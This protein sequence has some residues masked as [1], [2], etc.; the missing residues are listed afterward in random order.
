VGGRS[1]TGGRWTPTAAPADPG[2]PVARCL[3]S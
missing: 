2:T 1:S 3:A